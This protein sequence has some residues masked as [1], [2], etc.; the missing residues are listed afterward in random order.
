[1]I[2]HNSEMPFGPHK[3]KSMSMIIDEEPDYLL[4]LHKVYMDD[5]D[6]P[7]YGRM[8]FVLAFIDKY[9]E[10]IMDHFKEKKRKYYKD[11]PDAVDRELQRNVQ[12]RKYEWEKKH[13]QRRGL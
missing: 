2:G 8:R 11:N 6:K 7:V 4:R 13:R 3:G 5:P 1:M 9:Y 10:D 12:E